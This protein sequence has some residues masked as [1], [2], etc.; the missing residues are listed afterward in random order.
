MY[1]GKTSVAVG[2]PSRI[3]KLIED[4]CLKPKSIVIDFN[5]RN[6][7]KARLIDDKHVKEQLKELLKIFGDET[8]RSTVRLLIY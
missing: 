6:E 8:K 5:F 4:G 7:K 1:K 3:A 2:T